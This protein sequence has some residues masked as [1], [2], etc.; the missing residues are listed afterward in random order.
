[1]SLEDKILKRNIPGRYSS[2][3]GT[4]EYEYPRDDDD[5]SGPDTPQPIPLETNDCVTR[6]PRHNTGVKGVLSDY[7]YER[8]NLEY[9]NALDRHIEKDRLDGN[10]G[11]DT[12]LH[13]GQSPDEHDEC[14]DDDM[15]SEIDEEEQLFLQQYRDKRLVQFQKNQTWPRYGTV[16][17]V[18][19]IEFAETID[20]LDPRV[21]CVIHL[22]EDFIPDCRLLDSHLATLAPRMSYGCFLRL[23]ATAAKRDFDTIALP[24]VLIY[25]NRTLVANLTPIT[26]SLDRI[27]KARKLG[28][29]TVDDIQTI[30]QSHGVLDPN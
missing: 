6:P 17:T 8:Q 15:D 4:E 24:S 13:M 22:Y 2:W 9:A 3:E 20:D 23:Q 30:L 16:R 5:S 1:M 19:P 18:N 7:Q 21:C 14:G 28:S 26:A 11:V 29:F 10:S 25:R 27:H 12:N